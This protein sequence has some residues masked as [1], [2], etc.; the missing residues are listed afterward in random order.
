MSFGFDCSRIIKQAKVIDDEI[1]FLDKTFYDIQE[2]Y[3]VR[4]KLHR[5]VYKHHSNHILDFMVYDIFKDLM[6]QIDFKD[7]KNILINFTYWM[8]I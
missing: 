2:L 5:R 4:D 7:Y 3:E 6:I 8:I 1:C